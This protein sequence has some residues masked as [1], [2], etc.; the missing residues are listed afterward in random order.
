M[1]PS[2]DQEQIQSNWHPYAA[3]SG[4]SGYNGTDEAWNQLPSTPM[5]DDQIVMWVFTNKRRI[6]CVIR[7]ANSVYTSCYVGGAI[8]LSASDEYEMPYIAIGNSEGGVEFD[9]SN[10]DFI[11]NPNDNYAALCIDESG[12]YRDN[13]D[14][15][16][17]PLG[18]FNGP[19]PLEENT[20]GEIETYP[21]Y[22]TKS[23]TDPAICLFKLDG[24]R[25]IPYYNNQSEDTVTS[26]AKVYLVSQDC[27][28]VLDESYMGSEMI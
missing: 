27:Y 18:D 16:F 1:F 28:K 19:G 24:V 2:H 26:G 11:I 3:L 7:A 10:I 17:S 15:T 8:R 6:H 21:I 12:V 14:L 4:T 25:W 22:V 9:Q 23:S 13:S 5:N 20:L